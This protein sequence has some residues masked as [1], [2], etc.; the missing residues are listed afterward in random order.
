MI[1]NSI[2]FLH[3]HYEAQYKG[4]L[5]ALNFMNGEIVGYIFI[6]VRIAL[7]TFAYQGTYTSIFSPQ[8]S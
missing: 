6:Q 8:L 5:N 1:I 3:M 4:L 2:V 7:T